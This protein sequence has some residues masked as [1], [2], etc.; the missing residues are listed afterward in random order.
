M[1]CADMHIV[2]SGFRDDCLKKQIEEAGGH[3]TTALAKSTTHL[4]LKKRD[5]K[6]T[7][8]VSEAEDKG[9][10]LIYLDDFLDK[11]EFS[12]A[13]KKPRASKK[14]SDDEASEAEAEA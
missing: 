4:L 14:K 13:E 7:K 8:K 3:V 5:G 11:H 10:E 1:S 2:F 12:L 9:I 6:V